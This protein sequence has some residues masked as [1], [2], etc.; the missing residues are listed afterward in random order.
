MELVFNYAFPHPTPC[1]HTYSMYTR[2]ALSRGYLCFTPASIPYCALALPKLLQ[3]IH[4]KPPH[5]WRGLCRPNTGLTGVT[6]G[7]VF[8][9][10]LGMTLQYPGEPLGKLFWHIFAGPRQTFYLLVVEKRIKQCI[11]LLVG[12]TGWLC[13]RDHWSRVSRRMLF[14]SVLSLWR[15][16]GLL[17]AS[18]WSHRYSVA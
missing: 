5:Q 4:R 1:C 14:N 7:E 13:S 12:L 11:T 8:I 16:S 6:I 18:V 17:T 3:A 10:G 15:P 9:S 2:Y